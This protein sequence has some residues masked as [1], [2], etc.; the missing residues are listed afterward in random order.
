[1]L[2][3]ASPFFPSN[4]SRG[5]LFIRRSRIRHCGIANREKDPQKALVVKIFRNPRNQSVSRRSNKLSP[6][7]TIE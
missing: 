2:S 1:M 7:V 6:T 3:P 5:F 4:V